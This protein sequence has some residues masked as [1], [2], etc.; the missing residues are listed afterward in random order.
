[1]PP[2]DSDVTMQQI[3]ASVLFS[4]ELYTPAT[5]LDVCIWNGYQCNIRGESSFFLAY[6]NASLSQHNIIL[7]RDAMAKFI[8]SLFQNTPDKRKPS[9]YGGEHEDLSD[10]TPP[11]GGRRKLSISRSG[12]M[13]QTNR[14]RHSISLDIYGENLQSTEKPKS[15]EYHVNA[16][17][18]QTDLNKVDKQQRRHSSEVKT[19]E[20][21][22]DIAFNIIDKT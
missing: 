17:G 3:Q 21:E 6:T 22:I 12:R 5:P 11:M 7:Q 10:I 9:Q 16:P 2:I 8:K 18:K 1:M 15:V 4:N 13:K 19:P 14:K 20:E